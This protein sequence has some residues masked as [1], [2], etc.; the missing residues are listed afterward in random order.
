MTPSPHHH[1]PKPTLNLRGNLET[2]TAHQ[3]IG[4]GLEEVRAEGEP[5]E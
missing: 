5:G 2:S 1:T 3:L 4:S